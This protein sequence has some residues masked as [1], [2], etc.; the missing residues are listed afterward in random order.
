MENDPQLLKSTPKEILDLHKRLGQKQL[1]DADI[2]LLQSALH[3][4]LVLMNAVQHKT[5]SI[6]TLLR[7]IF[8]P[9]SEKSSDLFQAETENP[10]LTE[11]TEQKTDD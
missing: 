8:G 3:T 7:R 11:A 6:K 5:Q 9:T 1:S 10:P 2:E 4:I